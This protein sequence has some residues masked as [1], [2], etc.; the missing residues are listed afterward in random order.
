MD[1]QIFLNL[2]VADVQRS[3][4]FFEALGFAP[5]PRFTD[6]TAA[7]IM[8]SERI[9]AMLLSHDKFRGFAPNRIADAH[10]TT[11]VLICLRCESRE[12][13]QDLVSRARA[14]G[15]RSYS[16]AQDYGFMYG[17]GFQDPDGHVWE[18]MY[19]NEDVA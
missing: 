4:R 6:E 16:D 11:E 14:A 9:Y 7:G 19:M 1:R 12:E 2:P 15:G 17:H 8:I 18:L 3:I 5:D 10:E 13:V